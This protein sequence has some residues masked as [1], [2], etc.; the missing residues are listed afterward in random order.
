M[1]V[2]YIYSSSSTTPYFYRLHLLTGEAVDHCLG[3][4]LDEDL[5]AKYCIPTSSPIGLMIEF[6]QSLEHFEW[7]R[8]MHWW[9]IKRPQYSIGC[10]KVGIFRV[11]NI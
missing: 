10:W 5:K 7:R 4:L 11:R 1:A 2:S 6:L 9:G 8:D 3:T